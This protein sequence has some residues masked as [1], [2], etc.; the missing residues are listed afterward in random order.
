MK[1]PHNNMATHIQFQSVHL[2]VRVYMVIGCVME[3]RGGL[4]LSW[5]LG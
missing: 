5:W 3:G 2:G 4:L 1:E